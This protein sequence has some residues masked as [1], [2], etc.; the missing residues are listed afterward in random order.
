MLP[1]DLDAAERVADVVHP[2]YPEDPAVFAER[3]R[4]FPAG[5]WVLEEADACVGYL[6]GHPWLLHRPVP[7]NHLLRLL[8]EVPD[9][10][11]LHDLAL[12]PPARGRGDAGAGVSLL[13]LEARRLGL[14]AM[15]LVSVGGSAGFWKRHG[16][17]VAQDRTILRHLSGYGTDARFM[18]RRLG[19][20]AEG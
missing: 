10:F 18:L 1:G 3:L 13:V 19:S 20:L 2:D 14:G 11:Y 6:I 15:S 4:L 7:L 17:A 8:P 5:C 16:F 9:T 12:L